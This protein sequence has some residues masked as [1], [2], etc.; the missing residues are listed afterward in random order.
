MAM[1]S[2]PNGLPQKPETIVMYGDS[3]TQLNNWTTVLQNDV[4]AGYRVVNTALAGQT[5]GWGLANLDTHVLAYHPDIV[6]FE[7]NMNDAVWMS[8]AQSKA[9][10]VAIIDQIRAAD[11]HAEIF[12]ATN[13]E[14][15]A[16]AVANTLATVPTSNLANVDAYYQQYRDIAQQM[17]VGLIDNEPNWQKAQAADPAI[18]P[19]GFHPTLAADVQT[20][21]PAV[22]A[23]LGIP[24]HSFVSQYHGGVFL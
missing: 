4:G 23:A 18:V 13:N 11:P 7:F 5:S 3:E 15:T 21:I 14:P 2:A 12:L 22:L 10:V 9:N 8:L 24:Q 20:E 19:D 16:A 6:V 17:G 1:I